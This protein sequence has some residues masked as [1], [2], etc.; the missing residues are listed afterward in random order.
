MNYGLRRGTDLQR[1]TCAGLAVFA[2]RL[3]SPLSCSAERINLIGKCDVGRL[4]SNV[5]KHVLKT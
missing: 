4:M 3:P 5:H 2:L 1:V